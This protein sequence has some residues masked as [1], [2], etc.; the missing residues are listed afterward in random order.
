M[1]KKQRLIDANSLIRIVE[2]DTAQKR[3]LD[4]C[5]KVTGEMLGVLEKWFISEIEKCPTIN[6][7]PEREDAE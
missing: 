4:S 3:A 2:H 5:D 1:D 6:R 7:A